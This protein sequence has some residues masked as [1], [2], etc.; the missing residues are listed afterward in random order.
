MENSVKYVANPKLD[1]L[2]GMYGGVPIPTKQDKFVPADLVQIN[3]DG[4]EEVLKN[5]YT[6]KPNSKSV[7]E[8]TNHLREIATDIFRN[9]KRLDKPNLIEVVISVS[10]TERRFKE[11]DI[12]NLCKC[13]LDALNTVAF[14]DDSQIVSLIADKHIH[15]MKINALLIGITK[16]TEERKGF[17]GEMSLFG[18]G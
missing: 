7:E 16:L 18:K 8:F 6:K 3:D 12:D 15:P 2:F 14:E 9:G 17:R 11:V 5:F 10:I 13:I 1:F 4:S